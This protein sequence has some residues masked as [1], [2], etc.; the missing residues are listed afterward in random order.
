MQHNYLPSTSS[1]YSSDSFSTSDSLEQSYVYRTANNETEMVQFHG[2][3]VSDSSEVYYDDSSDED[4]DR[5]C[6][7]CCIFLVCLAFMIAAI[8]I[9]FVWFVFGFTGPE[10][11]AKV[12]PTEVYLTEN[13]KDREHEVRGVLKKNAQLHYYVLSFDPVFGEEN[14][15]RKYAYTMYGEIT[16]GFGLY[17]EVGELPDV[18]FSAAL[19]SG[20]DSADVFEIKPECKSVFVYCVVQ[21][22][23]EGDIDFD[24]LDISGYTAKLYI[25]KVRTL[26]TSEQVSLCVVGLI[27][28]MVIGGVSFIV[29]LVLEIIL[30]CTLGKCCSE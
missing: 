14:N 9:S 20:A 24:S 17:C 11:G 7:Y 29:L 12:L 23:T 16:D 22:D 25:Q 27:I 2:K 26:S 10:V 18:A 13:T 3:E 4:D 15:A 8:V 19:P 21:K 5:C 1:T 28:P 30:C 6:M